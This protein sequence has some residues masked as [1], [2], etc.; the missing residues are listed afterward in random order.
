VE[1]FKALPEDSAERQLN[2]LAM[3]ERDKVMGEP[4]LPKDVLDYF[5]E[6]YE[7]TGFTGGLN[8]YRNIGRIGAAMAEAKWEIE[9]P[10]LYIG[11]EHDVIL[12]PSSADGMEDFIEDFERHTIQDCG[13]WTQQEKPAEL[14]RVVID[15]LKRKIR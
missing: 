15:W 7:I 5:V 4:V 2:L 10:C 1:T 9:V 8:W 6:T 13:H 11:S 14:N 3:L 12:R